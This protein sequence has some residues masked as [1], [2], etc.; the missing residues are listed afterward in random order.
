MQRLEALPPPPGVIASLQAGFSIVSSRIALILL[1]LF[2]DVMLWLGPRLSV[3]QWYEAFFNASLTVLRQNGF[4]ARD[5]AIYTENAPLIIGYFERLNWLGW[6]RTLPV[7]IPALMLGLPETI[8]VPTPLGLQDVIQL[9][10][11][12]VVAGTLLLLTFGGWLGGGWYFRSVAGASLGEEE[13]AIGLIWTW[14]QTI[15]LSVVWM[16]G[17]MVIVLPILFLMGLLLAIH[18]LL[19]QVAFFIILFFLFW[20]VVP[21]FF[22][23]HGIFVRR[24][25]AFVSIL[26]SLRMSRFTLPNSSM[27]VLSVFLLSRGL[28]YLWLVPSSDS[29]LMLIGIAGH[30]FISTALLSASFVYYRNMNHWLQTVYEQFQKMSQRSSIRKA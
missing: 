3:G 5:M 17:L 8:P 1:P 18:P 10:S 20:L 22:M 15:L 27:F 25:N 19:A 7:G 11:F 9:P 26:S 21:L 28:S 30:A 16:I 12:M 6:L 4:P 14:L 2:L 23:P 29:W 13:P 24:Q